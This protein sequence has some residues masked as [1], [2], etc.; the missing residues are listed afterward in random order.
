MARPVRRSTSTG[1]SVGEAVT[2]LQILCRSSDFFLQAVTMIQDAPFR[3]IQSNERLRVALML[4]W[5]M[6]PNKYH[7]PPLPTPLIC[8]L[9]MDFLSALRDK[10]KLFTVHDS[11]L[12]A[13]LER[14]D[15]GATMSLAHLQRKSSDSG[16]IEFNRRSFNP[17]SGP[18]VLRGLSPE[19]YP[20]IRSVLRDHPY[21][22][23]KGLSHFEAQ[24]LL[25]PVELKRKQLELS[26]VLDPQRWISTLIQF[27]DRCGILMEWVRII[28]MSLPTDSAIARMV[29]IC[30]AYHARLQAVAKAPQVHRIR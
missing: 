1:I 25:W 28:G 22:L 30:M 10:N 2:M 21:E 17:G 15:R 29:E 18:Q 6:P 11:M 12:F 24:I 8:D 14:N 3:R 7:L 5:D 23:V 9:S 19:L 26:M 4:P 13:A 27:V 16:V 20:L